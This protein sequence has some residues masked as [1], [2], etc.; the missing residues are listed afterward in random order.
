M[1]MRQYLCCTILWTQHINTFVKW[2]FN[3]ISFS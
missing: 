3:L 1:V 2:N